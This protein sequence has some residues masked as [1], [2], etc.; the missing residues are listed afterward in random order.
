MRRLQDRHRYP[1]V[2][3]ALVRLLHL[4]CRR[5]GYGLLLQLPRHTPL[6]CMRGLRRKLPVPARL[7][8]PYQF[9]LPRLARSDY[10][11]CCLLCSYV[12]ESD[13]DLLTDPVEGDTLLSLSQS[14]STA[15]DWGKTVLESL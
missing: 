11:A 14:L 1:A 15:D 13:L 6:R 9:R 5:T 2:R 12:L 4:R 8:Q 7:L 3:T 10:C